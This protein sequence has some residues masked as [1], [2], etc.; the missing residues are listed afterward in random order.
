M[1]SVVAIDLDK[2][3]EFMHCTGVVPKVDW[4]VALDTSCFVD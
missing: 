3:V 2:G 4:L 1:G